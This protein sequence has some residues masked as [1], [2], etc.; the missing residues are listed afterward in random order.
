MPKPRVAFFSFVV[1]FKS[2]WSTGLQRVSGFLKQ[3]QKASQLPFFV[4]SSRLWLP[5]EA[6][7]SE[8]ARHTA[9]GGSLGLYKEAGCRADQKEEGTLQKQGMVEVGNLPCSSQEGG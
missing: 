5:A 6:D 7:S 3:G 4:K 8:P 2:D 1:A 9:A